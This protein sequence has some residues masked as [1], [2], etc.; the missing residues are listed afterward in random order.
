MKRLRDADRLIKDGL[1]SEQASAISPSVQSFDVRIAMLIEVLCKLPQEDYEV[2]K[3]AGIW[4]F[5]PAKAVDGWNGPV[6]PG[7]SQMVYLAPYLEKP[8]L[9]GCRLVVAHEVV[10]SLLGHT[11]S[12]P[13]V[14]AEKEAWSKVIQL[15]FGTLEDVQ[16]LL[17]QRGIELQLP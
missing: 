8:D 11:H 6:P 2:V 7:K 13:S 1:I 4:F 5:T 9:K 14:D 12:A 16:A 10:H 15:G 3:N 17:A